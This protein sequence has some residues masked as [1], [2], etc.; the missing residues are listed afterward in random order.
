MKTFNKIF[1]NI[2][3]FAS[4]ISCNTEP[5]DGE[6]GMNGNQDPLQNTKPGDF[7][8]D[9]DG[10]TFIADFTSVTF[11]SETIVLVGEKPDQGE[12]IYLVAF[13]EEPEEGTYMLGVNTNQ[14]AYYEPNGFGGENAWVATID[15]FTP[16]GEL[17]IL[18]IDEENK[19]I[20]GTFVFTGSKPPDHLNSKEFTNG[21][22]NAL[23]YESLR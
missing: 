3:V 13:G 20:S 22:F 15:L 2:V 16:R 19:T 17:V 18:E 21:V 11:Y 9:F 7:K 6:V 12:S 14:A 8:V 10:E 23:P 1:F 5:Y 4:L